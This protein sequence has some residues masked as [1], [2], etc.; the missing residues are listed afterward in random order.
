MYPILKNFLF[1][2]KLLKLEQELQK[3]KEQLINE[4]KLDSGYTTITWWDPYNNIF[5]GMFVTKEKHPRFIQNN[6]TGEIIELPDSRN[7]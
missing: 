3:L 2:K 7:F 5:D 6:N 1:P 4:E